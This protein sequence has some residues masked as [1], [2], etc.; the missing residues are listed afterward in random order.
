[1]K[2]LAIITFFA[3][4]GVGL[5]FWHWFQ[6]KPITV[7]ARN[8]YTRPADTSF[9][10][11]PQQGEVRVILNCPRAPRDALEDGHIRAFTFKAPVELMNGDW[12]LPCADTVVLSEGP[13]G[14]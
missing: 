6:K 5:P 10:F 1:M 7:Q 12:L 3:G 13:Q 2:Y 9:E 4:I 14:K 8:S 11:V